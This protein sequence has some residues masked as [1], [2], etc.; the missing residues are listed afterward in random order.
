[1]VDSNRIYFFYEIHHIFTLSGNITL[2]LEIDSSHHK[3]LDTIILITKNNEGPFIS[4]E[5][6]TTTKFI[7]KFFIGDE[8]KILKY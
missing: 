3:L 2:H 1:M 4:F 6:P 8:T 7:R 5:D